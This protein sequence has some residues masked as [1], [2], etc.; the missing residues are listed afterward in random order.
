MAVRGIGRLRAAGGAVPGQVAT[1]EF[2]PAAGTY[3]ET[4]EVEITCA[5]S[6]ATIYYTT[7]GSDPD[8]GD[9]EY[10]GAISVSSTQTLKAI[11]IKSGMTD[12]EIASAAY[13]IN[14]PFTPADVSP[15]LW[16]DA[17]DA[18]TFTY[19]S[20]VVVS[21]WNDKSGNARHVSQG[22]VASQPSR[23]TN[24]LNSLPVVRFDST[25]KVLEGPSFVN[26][27]T[28]SIFVVVKRTTDTSVAGVICAGENDE[29][30]PLQVDIRNTFL[31]VQND[32]HCVP[33]GTSYRNGDSSSL[34]MGAS[35]TSFAIVGHVCSTTVS[36]SNST[37]ITIGAIRN[38][39]GGTEFKFLGDMAE[40]I[41][42]ES[43]V[44]STDRQKIEG[45]LAWKWGLQANLVSGHPY[46]SA[47][48]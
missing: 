32:I 20:G 12:S 31:A 28:L 46:A 44:S 11:G 29:T 40:L 36:I 30:R 6:G 42:C 23:Q 45:Y 33:S 43:A 14:L 1:P 27:K 9:T 19:S 15:A 24:V 21:Q 26:G 13:T 7:D 41:I 3:T 47:A 48:P 35:P 37:A 22:T 25:G 8:S 2:S 10:T 34:G 17:S 38:N 18:S 39:D 16:L 5:T 4:Q